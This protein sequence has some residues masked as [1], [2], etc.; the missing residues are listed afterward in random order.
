MPKSTGLPGGLPCPH[1][2]ELQIC[3]DR[4]AADLQRQ[5][6]EISAMQ[7]TLEHERHYCDL[8][9]FAPDAYVVTNSG[10]KIREANLAAARLLGVDRDR[11]AGRSLTSFVAR[12][13]WHLF[14]NELLKLRNVDRLQE[15]ALR[16][17][18]AQ[19]EPFDASMRVTA[20]R[21]MD[22]TPVS[23]RWLIRDVTAQKRTEAQ[24][25]ELNT[26][27]EHRIHERTAE[28]RAATEEQRRLALSETTARR[29]AETERRAATEILERITEAFFALDHR[30][31]FTYI[32][33]KAEEFLER[34]RGALLG[35]CIWEEFPSLKKLC[36]YTEFEGAVESQQAAHFEEFHPNRL[37]WSEVHIYPGSNGISVYIQDITRRKTAEAALR[38][39]ERRY[40]QLVEMSPDPIL[41]TDGERIRFGNLA[42]ARM[43]EVQDAA[44][45]VGSP[46][47]QIVHPSSRASVSRRMAAIKATRTYSPPMEHIAVTAS[48]RM[49]PVETA[50]MTLSFE[51]ELCAQVVLRDIT[52]RRRGE[53]GLHILAEIRH[54]LGTSL[55]YDATLEQVVQ[56]AVPRLADYCVVVAEGENG[57]IR[58][59]G[60]SDGDSVNKALLDELS[61]CGPRDLHDAS[62]VIDILQTGR[63]RL[64]REMTPEMLESLAWDAR[65][66]EALRHLD[67]KSL[68]IAPL[69]ARAQ[70]L[71]CMFF[72]RLRSSS[73]YDELDVA[74]AEELAACCAMAIDNARLYRRQEE[75]DRGKEQFMLLLAHELRNP[76][77]AVANASQVIRMTDRS[78]RTQHLNNIVQRQVRLQARLVEDLLDFSRI[79]SG[80]LE[81][82][83][84]PLELGRLIAEVMDDY[85]PDLEATGVTVRLN[86]P[87]EPLWVTGDRARITQVLGN[88]IHNAGK[89]TE[90]GGAVTVSLQK[91][92]AGQNAVITIEDTGD[93]IECELL[94]H[95]WEPFTQRSASSNS[96]DGLGLGLALVH[97][98]VTLQGG[99][100]S[101]HSDGPGTGSTF[102][103]R[104]PLTSDPG[105]PT[106]PSVILKS[107]VPLRI[108]LIEDNRDVAETQRDVLELFNHVVEVAYSGP[109]GLESARAFHPDVVL[110]DV[111]LPGMDG[112]EF[113]AELRKDPAF[114]STRLISVSGYGDSGRS[115]ES[116]FDLHMEKPLDPSALHKALV[117]H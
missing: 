1:C 56:I 93:G 117:G 40:R 27:M 48:G 58:R 31:H 115:K 110:C 71:G 17:Q 10:G 19:G 87:S 3:L 22:V 49:V 85:W 52:D 106:A 74:L 39:S 4:L 2:A 79:R 14:Q 57:L 78:E 92:P 73:R 103:I 95:I 15:W 114:A 45:L 104:L 84:E 83:L 44:A 16:M 32:N 43:L 59:V 60:L 53:D 90:P 61:T 36:L 88:L 63:A 54:L 86:K 80:K 20:V 28:L 29:E 89:F 21:E 75:A 112:Y 101:A 91:C 81:L 65:H 64:F 70:T 76:L 38:K 96:R 34:P 82:R 51:G 50:S 13:D 18:P 42:L 116:G 12:K 47:E 94:N 41:V 68:I 100:V 8:F 107:T 6:A 25:R 24:I 5:Q 30:S 66:L 108:L 55:D 99:V 37:R 26:T 72:A 77:G 7:A 113:A 35:K 69:T 102:T 97:R 23:L 98:L 105:D 111:G 9:D 46:L 67:P 11:L 62:E 33:G 109:A